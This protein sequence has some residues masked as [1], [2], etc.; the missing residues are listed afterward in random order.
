MRAANL[1]TEAEAA[2]KWCAP[3]RL[4]SLT[5]AEARA[6]ALNPQDG[7]ELSGR[8]HC[9]ASECMLWEWSSISDKGY[10]G[11]KRR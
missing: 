4:I 8:L 6:Y 11:F 2:T 3:G 10:C 5:D 7:T 9:I 1:L